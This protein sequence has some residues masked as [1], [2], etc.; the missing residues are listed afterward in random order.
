MKP[1]YQF[2]YYID[3]ICNQHCTY[4]Y[5][6]NDF[7]WNN[8][9]NIDRVLEELSWFKD[10]EHSSI[11]TLIG[12]EPTLHPRFPKI[13]AY[14]NEHLQHHK[15]H[16]YTNGQFNLKRIKPTLNYNFLWTFSYHGE[17][18]KDEDVLISN[19]EYFIANNVEFNITIIAQNVITDR[20]INFLKDNNLNDKVVITFMHD[21][22]EFKPNSPINEK[23]N[24]PWFQTVLRN[25]TEFYD[26]EYFKNNA[27]YKGYSCDYNEIDILDEQIYADECNLKFSKKFTKEALLAIPAKQPTI[28]DRDY[29]KQDC[30]YLFPKK[31]K[32]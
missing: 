17:F 21:S 5:A 12:G 29:C 8:I 9:R 18:V 22:N 25:M 26:N 13:M 27:R 32:R 1:N 16:L 20:F 30:A 23:F 2:N 19:L 6:R 10:Y 24:D 11:I 14:M 28:C 31:T 15:L 4:C 3:T 7:E